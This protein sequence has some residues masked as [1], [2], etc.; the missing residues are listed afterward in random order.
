MTTA[1]D[2]ITSALKLTGEYG[3]G[4]TVSNDDAQDGLTALNDMLD[5]WWNDRL[6]V[7][8]IKKEN[9]PLV[10]A[11]Q[12]YTIGTGGDF[13]TTR[14]VKI[15][16]AFVRDSAGIDHKVTVLDSVQQY[17]RLSNKTTETEIP[18][19]L[20]YDS[21]YP[22]GKIFLYPVPSSTYDL[23]LFSW[24]QIQSFPTLTT[25]VQL[26][27]GYEMAMKFNL[28][29]ILNTL[30]SGAM[31]QDAKELAIESL[32]RIKRTNKKPIVAK[33]DYM[34]EGGRYDFTGDT[35]R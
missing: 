11:Q 13:N 32:A 33:M 17:N 23:F 15:V 20:Y 21:A 26:P 25:Q 31:T 4:E 30:F 34:T 6:A 29:K 12:S 7:F 8:E 24:K 22:L 3:A 35:Y 2:I 14:P 28:G 5:S 10:S 18:Y 19:Y 1:I 9:F 27:P 16:D